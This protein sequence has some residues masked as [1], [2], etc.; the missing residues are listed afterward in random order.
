MP[1][2]D[3]KIPGSHI[4]YAGLMLIINSAGSSGICRIERNEDSHGCTEELR[5]PNIVKD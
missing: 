1:Y 2:W 4:E 5:I 3:N